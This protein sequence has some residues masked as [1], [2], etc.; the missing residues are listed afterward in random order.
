[1]KLRSLALALSFAVATTGVVAPTV[2]AQ[3][4]RT[5]A[6]QYEPEFSPIPKP[7]IGTT[8]SGESATLPYSG[9]PS[10]TEMTVLHPNFGSDGDKENG[11]LVRV[12]VGDN[13]WLHMF[14]GDLRGTSASNSVDFFVAYPDGSTE[15]VEHT[16]TVYPLQKFLHSPRIDNAFVYKGV[17]SRLKIEDLPEDAQIQIIEAPDGWEFD[18]EGDILKVNASEAVTRDVIAYTTFADGSNLI[19]TFYISAQPVLPD[20]KPESDSEPT[21]DP[22]PAEQSGSSSEGTII[23]L[24]LGLLGLGGAAAFFFTQMNR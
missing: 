12:N 22:E 23:A 4:S 18:V 15:V 3:E 8:T 16:F 19:T 2:Q 1:M 14:P 20:S 10:G 6:E 13:I 7:F 21:P 11:L 24:I 17:E 9:V 5:M